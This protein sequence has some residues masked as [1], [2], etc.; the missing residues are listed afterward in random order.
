MG[1]FL[2]L[3]DGG[4]LH[5]GL[6]RVGA[7]GPARQGAGGGQRD[8]RRGRASQAADQDCGRDPGAQAG[9]WAAAAPADQGQM[10]SPRSRCRCWFGVWNP[11]AL[12]SLGPQR[13][14]TP[15][16]LS[17][18]QLEVGRKNRERRR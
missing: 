2:S 1:P 8:S 7:A 6:E 9:L 12:V 13:T 17:V 10:L 5:L 15:A 4:H 14:R 16:S 3:R 11:P 18:N